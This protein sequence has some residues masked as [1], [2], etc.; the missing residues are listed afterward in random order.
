MKKNALVIG[1]LLLL[2]GCSWFQK[3]DPLQTKFDLQKEARPK[4]AHV[5]CNCDDPD[6]LSLRD[7]EVGKNEKGYVRFSNPDYEAM[8]DNEQGRLKWHRDGR[9][10][11]K[12]MLRCLVKYNLYL[13]R[14]FK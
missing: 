10:Y 11:K 9:G 6:R 2:S 1:L 13:D 12:C 5:S 8:A 3:V 7:V 4:L 14:L